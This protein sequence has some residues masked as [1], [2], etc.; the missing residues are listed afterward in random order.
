MAVILSA[1]P[2]PYL[3]HI[4]LLTAPSSLFSQMLSISLLFLLS[5][6]SFF[7]F[8]LPLYPHLFSHLR[9]SALYREECQQMKSGAAYTLLAAMLTMRPWDD[10]VSNDVDR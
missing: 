5:S 3:P 6:P 9:P 8:P 10:V 4:T 1:V 2:T 7:R